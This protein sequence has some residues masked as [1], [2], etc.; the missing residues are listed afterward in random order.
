[1]LYGNVGNDRVV[2]GNN[3]GI[4]LGNL[5]D[6]TLVG[7]NSRELMIG[8]QGAD[9]LTGNAAGDILI[10]ASTEYDTNTVAH[11]QAL[12][13]ILHE[14]EHGGRRSGLLNV[15]SVF[16][17]VEQDRLTG[18]LGTDWFIHDLNDILDQAKNELAS[19]L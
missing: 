7:G 12:C 10:G 19:D 13:D 1:M 18:G 8:G 15:L 16:D 9:V 4:L 6:D 5:G 3:G 17:D 14:W 2:G 11:R